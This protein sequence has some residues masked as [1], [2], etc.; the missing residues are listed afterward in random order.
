MKKILFL[1]LLFFSFVSYG[2]VSLDSDKDGTPDI[3]DRCPTI[4][5]LRENER[6]PWQIVT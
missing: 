5:G 3:Y 6:C 2:Q 4:Y 1:P